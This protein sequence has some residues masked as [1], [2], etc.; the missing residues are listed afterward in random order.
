M[1]KSDE[2]IN[3]IKI[4]LGME[5]AVKEEFMNTKLED[6][7]NVTFD[8]LE[9]GSAFFI[10]TDSETKVPAP[11]GDY[12]LKDGTVVT[13]G[14]DNLINKVT[15]PN[16]P[17][18]ETPAEEV[19]TEDM[20]VEETP[21]EEVEVEVE[22]PETEIDP[23]VAELETKISDLE[24][25]LAEILAKMDEMNIQFSKQENKIEE[26]ANEPATTP[27]HFSKTVTDSD[28]PLS[29]YERRLKL[30]DHLKK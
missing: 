2:I 15:L 10:K 27:V 6:G 19:V 23:K 4:M 17:V 11:E 7:T 24:K 30:I 21:T 16:A 28:K 12:T 5:K 1:T 13:V 8:A 29:N 25:K 22:T 9:I 14:P 20:P 18:N 3:A 26:I